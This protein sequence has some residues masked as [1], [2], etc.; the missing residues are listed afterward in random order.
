[1]KKYFV[2]ILLFS[3]L[4][5]DAQEAPTAPLQTQQEAFSVK[6]VLLERGTRKPLAKAN[7]FI[8]P[9]KAK[10]ETNAKGEFEFTNIPP[11]DY[12]VIVN[13]TDYRKLSRPLQLE[14]S[15]EGLIFYIEKNNYQYFETTVTDSRSKKDDSQKRLQQE[16]FLQMPGSGGDPIKAVQNL[17]GVN[18]STGG[19][20][21]VIIQ[22]AEPEDT[23]YNIGGHQVPLIFHFGG[24]S[25][26]VT[27]EAVS[28]VDYYSAGYGPEFGRALG[29]H[30]GL[31]VRKP[32]TDRKHA[33][34]FADIYNL[35]G[36][37]EG[38]AGE[39][40]SYLVSA[41]YSYL[42][43]VLKEVAKNNKDFN[44]VV[45]P[46]FYDINAQYNKKL[47]DK[48]DFRLFSIFSKD[49]LQFVLSKPVMNDPALRGNF[50]RETEFYRLIPEW[51]R[52]LNEQE[53]ITTSLGV[54]TD[55]VL[56]DIGTNYFY[57][58]SNNLT[59]RGDYEKQALP[60][61]K[62]NLGFDHVYNW[63][64]INV[65]IPVTFSSGGV[66][67]PIA[68][69][70][71]RDATISDKSNSLGVYLRNEYKPAL[72]SKW[73]LFPNLR[74]DRYS[75]TKEV[76]AQPRFALRYALSPSLNLRAATGLYYQAPSGQQIDSTYG[77]P[78]VRSQRSLHYTVGFE[79]DHREG[80]NTGL[81]TSAAVFYKTLDNMIISST[82]IVTRNGANTT[83]NYNNKGIGNIQGIETQAKYKQELWSLTGSYTYLQSRRKSP[84]QVELPSRFDQTN[85]I[86]LLGSYEQNPV[87]YGVRVRYVTGN[88]ATP[89]IG[90]AF[91]SDNDV[92][93]PQRG[94][95][96][97]TRDRDFFQIDFRA[98]RKWVYDTWILSFYVD[99]QNVTAY[100]NQEGL[101][102]S[103]DYSQKQ[104]FTGLPTIPTIGLKGEF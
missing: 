75:Q 50:N 61:W 67:N 90:A 27:P 7:V 4:M 44:L 41:R 34:G 79:K 64:K 66:S 46:V 9:L 59:A 24:L 36:L 85:S 69:G 102:Y 11:G 42:G 26:I 58:K 32:K 12:E 16:D 78:S 49:Q 21:R 84:G 38:P 97:S 94:S 10:Q 89:V 83:E 73:T 60:N 98:D 80:S 100:K 82:D 48:D 71:V 13:I 3:S 101:T 57:L 39:D 72:E 91:D 35:G 33:M 23:L 6:G 63:Y 103:Y 45:A 95:L 76:F 92:Y 40:S 20:A 56:V 47:S 54:G 53:K 29:G 18:R 51:T 14:Q 31:N 104:E 1:M 68:S 28:S 37:V 81:V 93:S 30:V 43:L 86:N 65:R 52:Q 77:N 25:S 70:E 88:P 22:G 55:S 87:T 99:I 2:V 17:P 96:Y 5:A 8:L 15:K 62:Y 74:V 19:D